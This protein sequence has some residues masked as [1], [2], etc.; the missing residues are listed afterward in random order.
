MR[1]VAGPPPVSATP[2][3]GCVKFG[4][5]KNEIFNWEHLSLPEDVINDLE[6][7]AKHSL[8]IKTWS[9]YKTAERSLI[10]FCKQE[11]VP[12]TLPLSEATLVRYVHWLV[13]K[14]GKKAATVSSYLAGI[15]KLHIMK[16]MAAPL[17][18]TELVKMVLTGRKNMEDTWRLRLGGQERQPVTPDVLQLF[19][20]RLRD[21]DTNGKDKCTIWTVATL[22]FH[23][24]FRG[25]ELLCR[26]KSEFDPAFT[27]LR[28]D[29]MVTADSTKQ[30]LET[31]QVKLK[32]PKERKDN[33]AVI[34]D[35]FQSDTCICPVRAVKKWQAAT[36]GFQADQPAF[37]LA[38]GSPL[39]TNFFNKVLE[40]R[41]AGYLDD[42]KISAH[43]FRS[44]AASMMAN[45][46]YSDKDVKAVGRWS[47]RAFELYVKLP[48]TK[49]IEAA[50][51]ARK[52]GLKK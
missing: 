3:P 7:A 16:G 41:L 26:Q 12:Y 48:R 19:K 51:N 31:V 42:Y 20:A 45:L 52:F 13:Y 21:W 44:G 30:G 24:A 29:I 10:W 2:T 6:D 5:S 11:K 23:G 25:G 14:K 34:V 8:A 18:R 27:L 47:S 40:Q 32:A 1:L 35:V 28:Q 36:A 49:R 15:R 37:R 38:D 39:T 33:R 46:G 22:L 17:L 43:S 50:K 9:S 4:S